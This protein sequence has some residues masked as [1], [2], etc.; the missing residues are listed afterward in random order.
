MFQ[1]AFPTLTSQ[2]VGQICSWC[3]TH[4]LIKLRLI[5]QFS[6]SPASS[7]L[8]YPLPLLLPLSL[9]VLSITAQ[10]LQTS[11]LSCYRWREC[12]KTF[13][14]WITPMQC[15]M[16]I[17]LYCSAHEKPR[18][19]CTFTWSTV[20]EE[21]LRLEDVASVKEWTHLTH[22]DVTALSNANTHTYKKSVFFSTR[23]SI[24]ARLTSLP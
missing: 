12:S 23:Q 15:H 13:K 21:A 11:F 24:S 14:I 16:W 10:P 9:P 7:S 4:A 8:L 19:P 17:L 18:K 22:S 1:S 20:S 3:H 5:S 6:S 2:H